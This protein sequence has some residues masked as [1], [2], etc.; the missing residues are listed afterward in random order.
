MSAIEKHPPMCDALARVTIFSAWILIRRANDSGSMS[1]AIDIPFNRFGEALIERYAWFPAEGR[2][3]F[4][5]RLQHHDLIR[6]ICN[7]TK[8][9]IGVGIDQIAQF[10]E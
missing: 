4:Y 3:S 2:Q 10:H 9:K 1:F 6:P 5:I 8:P 7:I